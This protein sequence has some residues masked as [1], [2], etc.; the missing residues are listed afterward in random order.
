MTD[1][2]CGR[3]RF[4]GGSPARARPKRVSCRPR[5]IP[6]SHPVDVHLLF[7]EVSHSPSSFRYSTHAYVRRLLDHCVCVRARV[8]SRE[9]P[10]PGRETVS[11]ADRAS[12]SPLNMSAQP[13][14]PDSRASEPRGPMSS[15]GQTSFERVGA[16]VRVASAWIRGAT[17]DVVRYRVLHG[18]T[19]AHTHGCQCVYRRCESDVLGPPRLR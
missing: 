10:P 6:A 5:I 11:A 3:G 17:I 16:D 9:L 12:V 2:T 15:C 8:C 13:C 4:H 19:H 1:F 7:A 14:A 18:P